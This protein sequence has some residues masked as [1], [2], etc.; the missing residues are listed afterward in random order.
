M[1]AVTTGRTSFLI[2]FPSFCGVNHEQA[3]PLLEPYNLL[4]HTYNGK[5]HA[6]PSK[7][8]K[9]RITPLGRAICS[10]M[11]VPRV[12]NICAPAQK[13]TSNSALLPGRSFRLTFVP[14]AG[15]IC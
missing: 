3:G 15:S 1:T 10:Q 6:N 9:S 11:T 5:G 14:D 2:V 13:S 12:R 4:I 8:E 7:T